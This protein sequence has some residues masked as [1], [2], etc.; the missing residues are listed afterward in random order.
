MGAYALKFFTKKAGL[1]GSLAIFT[2]VKICYHKIILCEIIDFPNWT[3]TSFLQHIPDN[4]S[5]IS[6][7]KRGYISR[8]LP[9]PTCRTHRDITTPCGCSHHNHSINKTSQSASLIPSNTLLNTI[10]SRPARPP[11]YH[12]LQSDSGLHFKDQSR[13]FLGSLVSS[14]SLNLRSRMKSVAHYALFKCIR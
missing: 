13:V 2:F 5:F 9:C 6:R 4:C 7:I 12:L 10:Y 1:P 14:T 11:F 3:S 8:N